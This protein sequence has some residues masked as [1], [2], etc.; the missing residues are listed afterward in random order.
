MQVLNGE[1]GVLFQK[2]CADSSDNCLIGNQRASNSK[3][4]VYKSSKRAAVAKHKSLPHSIMPVISSLQIDDGEH[5]KGREVEKSRRLSLSSTGLNIVKDRKIIK[6]SNHFSDF[7]DHAKM[8]K[9]GKQTLKNTP[10]YKCKFL[11]SPVLCGG[12]K[13]QI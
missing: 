8:P 7:T 3:Q 1:V 4:R 13:L 5:G 6:A 2:T 11:F 10:F 9:Y 12:K